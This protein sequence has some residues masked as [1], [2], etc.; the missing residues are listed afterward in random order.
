MRKTFLLVKSFSR[1]FAAKCHIFRNA[2]SLYKLNYKLYTPTLCDYRTDDLFSLLSISVFFQPFKLGV[3]I[4]IT[5]LLPHTLIT[6]VSSS[7]QICRLVPH[8][9]V[10]VVGGGDAFGR[11]I[12]Y[13]IFMETTKNK[14]TA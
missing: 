8:R 14:N 3:R 12:K 9:N 7:R 2:I 10:F 1:H 11:K 6:L 4:T 5:D 13:V